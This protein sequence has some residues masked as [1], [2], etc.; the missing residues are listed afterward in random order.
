MMLCVMIIY[1]MIDLC[2][3]LC[4]SHTFSNYNSISSHSYSD[5]IEASNDG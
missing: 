3:V 4:E 1:P 2:C 5:L